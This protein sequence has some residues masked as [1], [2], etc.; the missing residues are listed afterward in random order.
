MT[1]E[2]ILTLI[3]LAHTTIWA[4]MAAA[5]VAIP[6]AAMRRRF[7]LGGLPDGIDRR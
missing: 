7:R 1:T 3:K 2:Q 4:I 5:I 6:V